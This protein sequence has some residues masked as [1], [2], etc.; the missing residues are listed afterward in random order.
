MYVGRFSNGTGPLNYH[1]R[2]F[3]E[4]NL[5]NGLSEYALSVDT[6]S[7]TLEWG[8]NDVTAIELDGG[9]ATTQHGLDVAS[10]SD[11]DSTLCLYYYYMYIGNLPSQSPIYIVE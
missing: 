10:Y 1:R 3:S 6:E 5:T 11:M 8:I 4:V 7:L 9:P 2:G